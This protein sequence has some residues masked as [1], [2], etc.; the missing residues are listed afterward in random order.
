MNIVY[1]RDIFFNQQMTEFWNNIKQPKFD[2]SRFGHW[3]KT[4]YFFYKNL[5]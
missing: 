3:S 4:N 1:I 5:I 2:I